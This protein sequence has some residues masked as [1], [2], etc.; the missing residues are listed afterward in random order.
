MRTILRI[1]AIAAPCLLASGAGAQVPDATPGG[2]GISAQHGAVARRVMLSVGRPR[3]TLTIQAPAPGYIHVQAP[4][5][6]SAGAVIAGH[7]IAMLLVKSINDS[8]EHTAQEFTAGI[9]RVL[10]RIDLQRT[11]AEAMGR[12]IDGDDR[13]RGAVLEVAEDAMDM[14]Q[15]GMLVRIKEPEIYTVDVLCHFG[16][17]FAA[18]QM[19]TT[20]RLWLK[21][22]YKP[23][24][25]AH[26]VYTSDALPGEGDARRRWVA[27]EGSP[28]LGALREGM[29]ETAR[30]VV[31]ETARR[32]AATKPQPD[33]SF[34][35]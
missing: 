25:S 17:E 23:V 24:F 18:L 4:P 20:I 15:P 30:L 33:A 14:E 7:I 8:G 27:E 26:V 19:T 6:T 21:D 13:L 3:D 28:L 32:A 29:A 1:T 2:I 35:R 12:A 5:G 34:P 16:P 9:D 10:S 11:L 22:A 31:A